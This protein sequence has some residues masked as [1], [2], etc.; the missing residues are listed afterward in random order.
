MRAKLAGAEV[1][2][3][4]AFTFDNTDLVTFGGMPVP[5]GKLDVK[6]TG[7][8]ALLDTLVSMGFIP[9]DQIMGARMMLAMFAKPG[10]GPDTL[11]STLEFKDKGFFANGKRLQ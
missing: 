1:S 6:M 9:E 3:T 7:I 8:N 4:G 2:G 11:V 10:D 5:T